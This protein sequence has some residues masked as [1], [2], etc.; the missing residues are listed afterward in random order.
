MR[1]RLKPRP[2]TLVPTKW[3]VIDCNARSRFV[4]T[5]ESDGL[6]VVTGKPY[7]FKTLADAKRYC[8]GEVETK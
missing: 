4:I 6:Y 1:E 2:I 7:T 3:Q 5:K 8:L